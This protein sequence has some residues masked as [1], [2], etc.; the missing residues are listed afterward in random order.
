MPTRVAICHTEDCTNADL[1]VDVSADYQD[2]D[3]GEW[4]VVGSVVCGVCDQPITDVTP[5]LDQ[6]HPDNPAPK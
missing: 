1:P 2:P 6:P 3:T 4:F 5:P